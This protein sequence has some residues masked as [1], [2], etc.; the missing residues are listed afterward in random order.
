MLQSRNY[1]PSDALAPYV[2]LHYVF[3][4][5]LPEDF[6]LIDKLLSENAMLRI[7][8]RGDWT[9]EAADGS[10]YNVGAVPFFGPNGRPFVARVRGPFTVAGMSLRPSGWCSLFDESAA[11]FLDTMLPGEQVWGHLADQLWDRLHGSTGAPEDDAH[12]I[13]VMEDVLRQ[14]L[15]RIGRLAPDAAMARFEAIARNDSTMRIEDAADQCGLSTRQLERRCKLSFGLS[16][17]AVLRRSRFLDTASAI[18]GFSSPTEG[19]LAALRYFDDSHLNREFRHF[20][21]MTPKQFRE[22]STPLLTAGL[23][24]RAEW[25]EMGYLPKPPDAFADGDFDPVWN[26]PM[27]DDPKA[28][29]GQKGLA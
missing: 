11:D 16:P 3:S 17:K 10:W 9:A 29:S 28:L 12:I 26:R 20:A 19:E 7:L 2:K 24:L 15:A 22:G 4:A 6:V 13:S 1:P 23:K 5:E 8:F 27:R 21:G 14:R 25:H 18:R